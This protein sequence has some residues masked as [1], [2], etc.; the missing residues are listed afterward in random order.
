MNH[1]MQSS[2]NATVFRIGEWII[3]GNSNRIVKNDLEIKLEPKVMQVLLCLIEHQGKTVSKD[4]LF[5]QVWAGIY[6]T[7]NSLNRSISLLRKAFDDDPQNPR[8]IETISKKGYRLIVAAEKVGEVNL[9]GQKNSPPVARIE[10]TPPPEKPARL[11][12]GIALTS[13]S[14]A[15]V[16]FLGWYSTSK[17]E[18]N[19]PAV[20]TFAE[21]KPIT[22]TQ[23]FERYPAFSPDQRKIVYVGVDRQKDRWRIFLKDCETNQRKALTTSPEVKRYPRF[24]PDGKNIAF[25]KGTDEW[26]GIFIVPIT[27]GEEVELIKSKIIYGLD[28]SPDGKWLVYTGKA[29]AAD[30]FSVYLLSLDTRQTHQ[31]VTREAGAYL[32][33]Y[34]AF[35]PDGKW[36]AYCRVDA[37]KNQDVFVVPVAGGKPRR[38]T[39]ENKEI[40]GLD[41][42]PDGESVYYNSDH[43]RNIYRQNVFD[44]ES[45][46]QLLIP[47]MNI[48]SEHLDI[49]PNGQ[50]V[51]LEQWTYLTNIYEIVLGDGDIKTEPQKLIS[52]SNRSDWNAQLSPSGKWFAFLSNRSGSNELWISDNEGSHLTRLT[53]LD[54][55]YESTHGWSPDGQTIAFTQHKNG[56]YEIHT[57]NTQ[58]KS[59]KRLVKNGVN[60]VYSRDGQWIYFASNR[61]GAWQIW[62]IPAMGGTAARLTQNGGWRA[63]EAPDGRLYFSKPDHPGIWRLDDR[64]QEVLIIKESSEYDNTNWRILKEGIFFIKRMEKNKYPLIAFYE[65]SGKSIREITNLKPHSFRIRGISLAANASRLLFTRVDRRECNIVQ[66]E[67]GN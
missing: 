20:K 34:P 59:S 67:F 19:L 27:G 39:A 44:I 3:E 30:P 6:V 55:F 29:S 31:L 57:I 22:A 10:K 63:G 42:S 41:W 64:S 43:R 7:E 38:V 15:I 40:Y 5:V 52:S 2:N 32:Y 1:L 17:V 65:F 61:S 46:P 54:L 25:T 23:G 58:D 35:S 66:I 36:I 49:S 50:H 48:T 24:S 13:L 14:V 53:S 33:K 37:I 45:K 28:W 62:K 8:F 12:L 9:N 51:L 11:L 21:I 18:A 16:S 47:N 26:A 56:N 60:P 4:D